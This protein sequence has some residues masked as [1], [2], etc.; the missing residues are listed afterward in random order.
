M[1]VFYTQDI[2]DQVARRLNVA[3]EEARKEMPQEPK[4]YL[5][6]HSL[7]SVILYDLLCRQASC[8]DKDPLRLS[9]DPACLYMIGSPLSMS[10]RFKKF[11]LFLSFF[12][13]F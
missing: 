3:M 8:S 12:L 4:V 1:C 7:G 10:G 6:G 9:F 11:L 2:L 5:V 13:S